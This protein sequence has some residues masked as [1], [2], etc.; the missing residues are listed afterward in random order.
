[1]KLKIYILLTAILAVMAS[2]TQSCSDNSPSQDAPALSDNPMMSVTLSVAGAPQQAK[3]GSDGGYE[4]GQ[5]FEN[6]IDIKNCHF[7]FFSDDE[8]PTYLATFE[9]FI[10]PTESTT[11]TSNGVET[12]YLYQFFGA[13]P[14]GLPM[15]FRLVVL[16][17]WQEYPSEQET[18]TDGDFNLVK[19]VT[20]LRDVLSHNSARFDAIEI[21]NGE[22]WLGNDRL[23]PFY[24]VRQY[25]LTDYVSSDNIKDGKIKGDTKVDLSKKLDGTDT[26]LPLIRAMAKVE[27]ILAVPFTS[28]DDVS[29]DRV[30]EKGYCAPLA[31]KHTDYDHD[32]TW[33]EDF[34]EVHIPSDVDIKKQPLPLKKTSDLNSNQNTVGKWIAYIPEYKNL[35]N[36]TNR[37]KINVTIADKT[38]PIYFSNDGTANSP[39]QYD[40]ERNNIYRFTITEM[41]MSFKLEVDVTPYTS[42]KLEPEFGIDR[43]ELGNIIDKDGNLISFDGDGNQIF[44]DGNKNI[45]YIRMKDGKTNIVAK[46]TIDEEKNAVIDKN[47]GT[48]LV[49]AQN[50]RLFEGEDNDAEILIRDVYNQFKDKNGTVI[51]NNGSDFSENVFVVVKAKSRTYTLDKNGNVLP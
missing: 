10:R 33:S 23:I 50:K 11:Q 25:N 36:T 6:H 31:L 51:T 4:A 12:I 38:L 5:G 42:V 13:V 34:I 24:G 43:D 48:I 16:A 2:I 47:G 45:F 15:K 44:R 9:P 17:N 37:C 20:K 41:T 35:G 26:S 1:M 21:A 28:F 7:F 29:I 39:T 14:Q 18:A 19:G 30:N 46:C 49:S 3:S 32:Y 8:E 27:V 22:E 40:V